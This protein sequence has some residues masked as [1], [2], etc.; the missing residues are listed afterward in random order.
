MALR[1]PATIF[2]LEIRGLHSFVETLQ[3]GDTPG[4]RKAPQED[5]GSPIG[6]RVQPPQ[7]VSRPLSRTAT[8]LAPRKEGKPVETGLDEVAPCGCKS[9]M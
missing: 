8:A 5:G 1:I 4:R 2:T 7:I 9:I 3:N 6:V